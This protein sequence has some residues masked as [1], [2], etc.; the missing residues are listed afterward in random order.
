MFSNFYQLDV[1]KKTHV[2]M[3]NL[4]WNIYN[5]RIEKQTSLDLVKGI[6]SVSLLIS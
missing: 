4:R 3:A 1:H 5:N 6:G 2:A